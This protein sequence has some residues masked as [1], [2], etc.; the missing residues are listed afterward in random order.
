MPYGLVW[1]LAVLRRLWSGRL[2]VVVQAQ[3]GCLVRRRHRYAVILGGIAEPRLI[4]RINATR[5]RAMT[6]I[7]VESLICELERD[8]A[9]FRNCLVPAI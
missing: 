8:P 5:A 1:L 9:R 3:T 6:P 7:D 4:A 2:V